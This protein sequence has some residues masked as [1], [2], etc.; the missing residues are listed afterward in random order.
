[1]SESKTKPHRDPKKKTHEH[2]REWQG[3]PW[4]LEFF[5]IAIVTYGHVHR[6]NCFDEVIGG[7]KGALGAEQV[8]ESF[9]VGVAHQSNAIGVSVD[10]LENVTGTSSTRLRGVPA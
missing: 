10:L 1:M 4:D 3:L 2:S 8:H 7:G 6:T 9:V 5:D